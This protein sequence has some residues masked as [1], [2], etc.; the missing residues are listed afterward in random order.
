MD[1]SLLPDGPGRVSMLLDL[2]RFRGT[3]QHLERQ[4]ESSAFDLTGD[5]FRIMAQVVL[6]AEV[7]KD[8]LKVRLVGR[9]QTTLELDCSRC[10]E[11]FAVPIDAAFDVLFLP[12]TANAGLPEREVSE[13]ELGASFYENDTID[14]GL[15]VREQ[16]YLALPMKPLCREDCRGL[17]PV[18]GVNWNQGSCTCKTE[19]VDPRL[20]PLKKL[21]GLN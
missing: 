5:E 19:W 21:K 11:P 20:E 4:Y 9:V 2:S 10:V 17:C 1:V 8:A 6:V 7:R 18:C 13:D 12:H 15:L 16:S 14:L 3:H